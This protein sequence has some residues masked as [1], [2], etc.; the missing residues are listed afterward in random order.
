[1]IT[2][3]K[4]SQNTTPV[5][6]SPIHTL[7][8]H[9]SPVHNSPVHNSPV[10]NSPIRS[11]VAVQDS[12]VHDSNGEIQKSPSLE[13]SPLYDTSA[14]PP[15]LLLSSADTPKGPPFQDLLFSGV[16]I[17]SPI[18]PDPITPTKPKYDSSVGPTSRR[19]CLFPLPPQPCSLKS[20]PTKSPA[21]ISG[22]APHAAGVNAFSSTSTSHSQVS[23]P[24]VHVD[25]VPQPSD[26]LDIVELSDCEGTPPRR[27]PTY[28]PCMEENNVSKE[29]YKCKEIPAPTLICQLSQIQWDLFY[30]S[31]S[32]FGE[33]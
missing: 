22:F 17:H 26:I 28:I 23:K 19:T 30:K 15:D 21:S 3:H 25:E 32:K 12:Q 14:P 5:H 27:R 20:S 4:Q 24:T 13:P 8:G 33:A 6:N 16:E 10:H 2:V 1:D 31:I 11:Q 29:L 7:L 18:S 9:K